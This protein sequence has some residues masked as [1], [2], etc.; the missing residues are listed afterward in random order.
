MPISLF[1]VYIAFKKGVLSITH[2]LKSGKNRIEMG[3]KNHNVTKLYSAV[4][5]QKVAF[6][7]NLRQLF[8]LDLGHKILQVEEEDKSFKYI[9][10]E[11]CV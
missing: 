6:N 11:L 1:S 10:G 8:S 5:I 7:P 4:F 3:K 2:N 9:S